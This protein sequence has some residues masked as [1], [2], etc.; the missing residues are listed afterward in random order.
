MHFWGPSMR[1]AAAKPPP[2]SSPR[3]AAQAQAGSSSSSS[4]SGPP[5]SRSRGA[6]DQDGWLV[7][8]E[9]ASQTASDTLGMIQVGWARGGE[10]G[11][12]G[13]G[14]GKGGAPRGRSPP[15]RAWPP[16]RLPRPPGAQP[17]APRRRARGLSH[18]RHRAPQVGHPGLAAG[19]AARVARVAGVRAPV[20]GRGGRP[21][22]WAARGAVQCLVAAAAAAARLLTPP[23]TPHATPTLAARRTSAT[24]GETCWPRSASGASRC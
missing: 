9:G 22:R 12:G 2:P 11:G 3:A 15:R 18:H 8:Y 17:Q 1:W 16:P 20:R 24:G 10:G 13:G 5:S 14:G 23:H 21:L 4:S 7:D 6:M 19:R